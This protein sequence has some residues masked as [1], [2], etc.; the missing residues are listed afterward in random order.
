MTEQDQIATLQAEVERLKDEL[1]T[2]QGSYQLAANGRDRAESAL[3][4]ER[5]KVQALRECIQHNARDAKI[6]L[7][8]F[9]EHGLTPDPPR[10][11]P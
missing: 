10:A 6:I 8:W 4:A 11:E 5:Q 3:A 9:D 2:V 7:R 1:G